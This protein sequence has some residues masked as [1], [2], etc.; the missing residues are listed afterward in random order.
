[1]GTYSK[2][3]A[4][5]LWGRPGGPWELLRVALNLDGGSVS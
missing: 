3:Q 4:V 2:Q 5:L 1:M